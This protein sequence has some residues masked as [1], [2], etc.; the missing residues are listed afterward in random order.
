[1]VVSPDRRRLWRRPRSEVTIL[2]HTVRALRIDVAALLL[3]L[4][5]LA[6]HVVLC[7]GSFISTVNRHVPMTSVHIL[8][9]VPEVVH[10]GLLAQSPSIFLGG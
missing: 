6:D 5:P 7:M 4:A 1:M 9:S 3:N 10:E 2:W 8:R